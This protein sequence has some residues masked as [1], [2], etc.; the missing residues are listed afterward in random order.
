[1]SCVN[2]LLPGNTD[3][4]VVYWV[5][6]FALLFLRNDDRDRVVEAVEETM[7]GSLEIKISIY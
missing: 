1:M 3:G 6:R 4:V 5:A 2:R 7:R